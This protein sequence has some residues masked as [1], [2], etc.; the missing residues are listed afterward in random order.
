M[1]VS[2]DYLKS[3]LYNDEFR[4]ASELQYNINENLASIGTTCQGIVCGSTFIS[5][6]MGDTL[7]TGGENSLLAI[8]QSHDNTLQENPYLVTKTLINDDI[9]VATHFYDFNNQRKVKI[10]ESK[11][12]DM[13]DTTYKFNFGVT[14]DYIISDPSAD[15]HENTFMLVGSSYQVG[16]NIATTGTAYASSSTQS[17]SSAID[18]NV[19]TFWYNSNSEPAV[20]SWWYIDFGSIK[21]ILGAE[22]VNYS[23]TY[24]PTDMAIQKSNDA[25]N[26]TQIA[27]EAPM[28]YTSSGNSTGSYRFA[29]FAQPHFARYFRFYCYGSNNSTYNIAR[30]YRLFSAVGSG[31]TINTPSTITNIKS[32]RQMDT[33]NWAQI[34]SSTLIGDVPTGTSIKMLLSFDDQATWVYWNG[35]AW[36]ASSIANIESASMSHTTFNSLTTANYDA[37]GGLN[38]GTKTIDV[39][40]S[41]ST[42]DT[43]KTP[44]VQQLEFNITTLPFMESVFDNTICVRNIAPN[45]TKF[46]NKSGSN[47]TFNICIYL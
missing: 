26:W 23:T 32:Q 43:S 6:T 36:T 33:S 30:E 37:T 16:A 25:T 11:T 1:S 2:Y 8:L 35:S 41:L 5:L 7:T 22:I 29:N 45:K 47:K 31:F 15:I 44:S 18:G 34:N 12:E 14:A 10:S 19:N 3:D 21:G 4:Y 24:F 46:Q 20:G 42:T 40:L 13:D 17:P 38:S 39:S 9:F 28:T 27:R